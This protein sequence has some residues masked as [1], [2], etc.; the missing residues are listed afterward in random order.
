[1]PLHGQAPIGLLQVLFLGVP[2]DA[3][4]FVVVPLGHAFR[5]HNKRTGPLLSPSRFSAPSSPL[6]RLLVLHLGELGIDD[7]AIVFLAGL[8]LL[9]RPRLRTLRGLRLRLLLG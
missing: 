2:V 8:G 5:F 7:I 3:E 9:R 4:Y 1:M 6:A